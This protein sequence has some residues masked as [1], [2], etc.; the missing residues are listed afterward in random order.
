MYNGGCR[1]G[2]VARDRAA[3]M[4]RGVVRPA[5]WTDNPFNLGETHEIDHDPPGGPQHQP[6]PGGV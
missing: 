3:G 5:G 1:A 4:P 6:N 2:K